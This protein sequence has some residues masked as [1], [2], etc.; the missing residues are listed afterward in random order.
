MPKASYASPK[1][2]L[3]GSTKA[4]VGAFAAE[5]VPAYTNNLD[6]IQGT[7]DAAGFVVPPADIVNAA[8]SAARGDYVGASVN[9]VATIPF[10]GDGVKAGV[11]TTKLSSGVIVVG[12]ALKHGDEAADVAAQV[13]KKAGDIPSNI[14]GTPF[15]GDNAAK[16][17]FKHLNKYHGVDPKEA[18]KLLHDIKKANGFSPADNM[19]IG[20]SGDVY[21]PGTGEWL[22][23]L[24]PPKTIR[25]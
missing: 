14:P 1:Q 5:L 15:Y 10:V 8:I 16:E 2:S 20:K 25:R 17:A 24:T 21:H 18:S 7:L 13:V 19:V 12:V 3:W 6:N 22:G 11:M 9:A 23:T 4:F